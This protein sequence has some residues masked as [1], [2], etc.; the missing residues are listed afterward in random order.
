MGPKAIHLLLEGLMGA[1]DRSPETEDLLEEL[2][3]AA[4]EHQRI[5]DRQAELIRRLREELKDVS[6]R[7]KP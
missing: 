4:M 1:A 2:Q 5:L 7:D 6:R 3:R